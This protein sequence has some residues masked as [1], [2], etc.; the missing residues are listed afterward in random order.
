MMSTS[1]CSLYCEKNKIMINFLAIQTIIID[2][3]MVVI[4]YVLAILVFHFL[5]LLLLPLTL[6]DQPLPLTLLWHCYLFV[7]II[8]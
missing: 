5:R 3:S 7:P 4:P 1:I 8:L 6:E 2:Q